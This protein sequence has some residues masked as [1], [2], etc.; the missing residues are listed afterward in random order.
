MLRRELLAAATA[1]VCSACDLAPS[2]NDLDELRARAQRANAARAVE[3][4]RDPRSHPP[5]SLDAWSLEVDGPGGRAGV[6]DGK[7]LDAMATGEVVTV[8]PHRPPYPETPVH[9]RTIPLRTLLE[10]FFPDAKW[11]DG[12][13]LTLLAEDAY[14]ATIPL[15]DALAYPMGLAV[16][17]DG[18]LLHRADCGPLYM[19]HPHRAFPELV[20]RYPDRYWVFYVT[21]LVATTEPLRVRIPRGH[22]FDAAALRAL[23]RRTLTR[24][25]LYSQRW[26]SGEVRLSGVALRDLLAAAGA[27]ASRGGGV[28]VRGK[29]PVHRNTADPRRLAADHVLDNDVILATSWGDGDVPIPAELGGPAVIALPRALDASYGRK[30]WV[31]FVEELEVVA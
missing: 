7:A 23:P 6:L 22:D 17:R 4:D 13:T 11:P 24:P 1:C 21:A 20:E 8:S 18:Q 26:P 29:A 9:F 25:V 28:I 19:V 15:K 27:P 14:R 16:A 5:D 2:S 3:A 30:Y 10:R 31:T 12:A